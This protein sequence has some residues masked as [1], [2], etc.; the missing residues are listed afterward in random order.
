M[1]AIVDHAIHFKDFILFFMRER[2]RE[3]MSEQGEGQRERDKQTLLSLEPD[4]G[5][6]PMALRSGPD[7]KPRVR[8]LTY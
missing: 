2:E 7:L 5:L 8:C 1:G 6:G 4:T 3:G